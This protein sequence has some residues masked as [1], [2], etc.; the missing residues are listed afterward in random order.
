MKLAGILVIVCSMTVASLAVQASSVK[1]LAIFENHTVTIP[2]NAIVGSLETLVGVGLSLAPGGGLLLTLLSAGTSL[3]TTW[4][5]P[6]IEIKLGTTVSGY[7]NVSHMNGSPCTEDSVMFVNASYLLMGD[8]NLATMPPINSTFYRRVPV[9]I[10]LPDLPNPSEYQTGREIGGRVVSDTNT[11]S[12]SVYVEWEL[13]QV[14]VDLQCTTPAG[15]VKILSTEEA[16]IEIKGGDC[17][18][19]V[20]CM[21]IENYP[22]SI[23]NCP[24][25]VLVPIGNKISFA[26]TAED[27]DLDRSNSTEELTFSTVNFGTTGEKGVEVVVEKNADDTS[28]TVTISVDG[29]RTDLLKTRQQLQVHVTDSFG[30]YDSSTPITI[31]FT[32]RRPPKALDQ[33]LGEFAVSEFLGLFGTRV[34]VSM[35][36]AYTQ[37]EENLSLRFIAGYPLY[38]G[39][40]TPI[41][42]WVANLALGQYLALGHPAGLGALNV[43]LR[44]AVEVTATCSGT[45]CSG[46]MQWLKTLNR[47][48]ELVPGTYTFPYVAY[49]YDTKTRTILSSSLAECTLEIVP[50]VPLGSSPALDILQLADSSCPDALGAGEDCHR[51][52][53]EI[54]DLD[55]SRPLAWEEVTL[56]PACVNHR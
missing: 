34:T 36:A 25:S 28:A 46:E 1:C 52:Q 37:E 31:E 56:V 9:I 44:D 54:V 35:E 47:G 49:V 14:D 4:T 16:S 27:F 55:L 8:G 30:L 23:T 10:N 39:S 19:E 26:V 12:G 48:R 51:F 43:F 33:S 40:H 32:T 41:P 11:E 7:V 2:M 17:Q 29:S 6:D 24:K 38:V 45:T 50:D 3:A 18:V 15:V 21:P 13:S 20:S 5:V 53:V 42:E 22:P